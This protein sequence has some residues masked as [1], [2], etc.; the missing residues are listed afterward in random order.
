MKKLKFVL[1]VLIS[2]VLMA[3]CGDESD[4][5]TATSET[6]DLSISLTDA[7]TDEYQAVYVT[8]DE[9]QVH[10]GGDEEDAD[11]WITV[12]TPVETYNLLE[13][14]NG[15]IEELGISPLE[16]GTYEQMRLIIGTIPADGLNI[17]YIGHPYANY[18]IDD[19]NQPHKLRIPSSYNTGVKIVHSFDISPDQTTELILDFDASA[20]VVEVGTSI[21]WL[22]K[23]TIKVLDAQEHAIVSGIVYD[24]ESAGIE[25]ALVNLQYETPDAEDEK[26]TVTVQAAT[27][28][29][30]ENMDEG[31]Q[32]GEFS[33]LVQPGSYRLV[34]YKDDCAVGCYAVDAA[35][36]ETTVQDVALATSA[37]GT[38]TGAVTINGGTDEQYATLS[39]RQSVTCEGADETCI[40]EVRSANN[41][42][43]YWYDVDLPEGTYS[44][45][46]SGSGME[47]EVYTGIVVTNGGLVTQHV[48]LEP[49]TD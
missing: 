32:N 3:A 12:A 4:N 23:P 20:S 47:T 5:D 25:G 38:V 9:I 19:N 37:M 17:L 41:L 22:L 29:D 21:N 1:I 43:G 27:V 35:S 40:I 45:S 10:L 28:S 24:S 30:T 15:V 16:A 48:N 2:C 31:I 14:V 13:L 6:G 42:T 11:N 36:G 49:A 18:V 7:A 8:I 44:L 34:A 26:D 46:V 33:L 39:F